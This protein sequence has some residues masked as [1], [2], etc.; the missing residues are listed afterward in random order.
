MSCMSTER[1]GPNVVPAGGVELLLCSTGGGEAVHLSAPAKPGEPARDAVPDHYRSPGAGRPSLTGYDLEQLAEARWNPETLCGREWVG[2]EP[3]DGGP[4]Y[5]SD[6]TPEYV[7]TCKSC[8]AAMDKLFPQPAPAGRLPLVVE[9]LTDHVA[10]RGYAE[11]HGVP[12]DQQHHLRVGVRA[13]V[14]KRTG[15][16]SRTH[17]VG[18]TVIFWSD[19]VREEHREEVDAEA[20]EALERVAE[21][22]AT[23][24]VPRSIPEWRLNWDTWDVD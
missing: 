6:E 21:A 7:P 17:A 19:A 20:A 3:G 4:I 18:G 9:L 10:G 24:E 11:I 16:G 5:W 14:K 15:H 12:G 2:M 23:G 1:S 13:A 22:L 8:L